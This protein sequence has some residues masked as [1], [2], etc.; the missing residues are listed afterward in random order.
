MAFAYTETNECR[1]ATR[2][3]SI[4]AADGPSIFVADGPSIY[5]A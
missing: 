5:A 3:P 2:R 1:M 4:Y